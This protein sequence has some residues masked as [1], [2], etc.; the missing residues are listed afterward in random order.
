MPKL[1]FITDAQLEQAVEHLLTVAHKAKISA[2]KDLNRNVIDPFSILFQLSGFGI[3]AEEW[4]IGEMT[5]QAEKTLQ[6]HVGTFHQIILGSVEGWKNLETGKIVDL[7]CVDR[8]IIAEVKNK[9]NTVSGGKLSDVYKAL[10]GQVTPKNSK[11]KDYT[12]YFVQVIPKSKD[13][14]DEPFT[15]SNAAV[16]GLCAVNPF[17]RRIDGAS[18][19][20]IATGEENALSQ[21]FDALPD[22]IETIGAANGYKFDAQDLAMAKSFFMAAYGQ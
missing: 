3:S 8:K 4:R 6:N 2:E 14:Y 10:E 22:V 7:E 19:Y 15:P 20:A 11:Y 21:L 12:A 5:R 17:I 18:F 9:H 1:S 16:G 13:R